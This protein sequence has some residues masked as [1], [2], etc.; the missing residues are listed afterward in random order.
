M[1]HLLYAVVNP[2]V[3]DISVIIDALYLTEAEMEQP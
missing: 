1:L 3:C 2:V